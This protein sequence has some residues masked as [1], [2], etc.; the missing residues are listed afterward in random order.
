[1]T[2][3]SAFSRLAIS[4]PPRRP[5]NWILIPFAPASMVCS[6]DSLHH[7]TKT[8]SLAQLLGDIFRDQLRLQLRPVDFVDFQIHSTADQ[9]LQLV[10]Q[11]FDSLDLSCR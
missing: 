7:A 4:E 5:A 8:S 10:L 2:P 9:I 11:Q 3:K 1:L 6:I